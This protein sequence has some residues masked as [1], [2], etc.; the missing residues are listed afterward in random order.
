MEKCI[1]YNFKKIAFSRGDAFSSTYYE[2]V[3]NK[4]STFGHSKLLNIIKP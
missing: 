4:L 2:S 1:K 3:L